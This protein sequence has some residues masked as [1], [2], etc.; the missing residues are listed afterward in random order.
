MP[1]EL[2]NGR[3]FIPCRMRYKLPSGKSDN[4]VYLLSNSFE[5][6]IEMIKQMPHPKVDYRKIIFPYKV[7][8]KIDIKPFRFIKTQNDNMRKVQYQ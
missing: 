5:Y 8:D 6:D 3:N 7:I 1:L 4:T 2:S